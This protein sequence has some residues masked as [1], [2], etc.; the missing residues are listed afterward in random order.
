MVCEVRSPFNI[1]VQY[2][3]NEITIMK[4]LLTIL[5]II[6]CF[7]VSAQ[8]IVPPFENTWYGF[9]VSTENQI[10]F[11]SSSKM[12][13]VDNDGD[14][15]VVA[16]RY[17]AGFD[18]SAKGFFVIKNY[19]GGMFNSQAAHY[20]SPM[21]SQFAESADLNNDNLPDVIVA[22]TGTNYNGNTVS[23][24][25][26]QGGGNFGPFTSYAVGGGP[27]GIVSDDFNNDG[28]NDLAVANY[29]GFD[30]GNTI[31]VLLNNG[32]GTF[33]P[34]SVFPAG[35]APY[36]LEAAKINGDNF[37]DIVVANENY[38]LNVLINSGTGTFT[39]RTELTYSGSGNDVWP[40]VWL[41][42]IDNDT[43][44]DIMYACVASGP[45]VAL[46]RNN[47]GNFGPF[48]T[49]NLDILGSV[50]TDIETSD[51]NGDGWQDIVGT[52]TSARSSDGYMVALSNGSGGFQTA[53]KNSAGQNTVDVML[54]DA[55]NDG[56]TDILTADSFSRMI[57]I[58]K[59]T[60]GGVFYS[61]VLYQTSSSFAASI[62]AADIDGDNDLDVVTSAS[63]RTAT[64]VPV[65][66][67]KNNGDGSF[68]SAISYSIRSGG[69]QA[70]FRDLNGD[71]KPDLLFATAINSPPYD[72][73]FAI[74]NGD[75]TFGAVQTK[76]VN[77]CGWY[78]IDG[79]DIDNDGDVDVLITEWLGCVGIPESGQRLFISMNDGNANFS[80]PAVKII[81]PQPAPIAI[82]DFN[83]DGNKDLAIGTSGA[84]MNILFGTGAGSFNDP[85]PNSIGDQGGATDIT[86]ADFNS[87]G[88]L[89]IASSNFFETTW[90]SVLYGNSDGTFQPAQS[91][92]SAYSPDL[93]NVSGITSGDLDNDGDKDIMV[94]NNASNCISLYYNN[95]G[96]F[97][98]ALRAGAYC[99]V[100]SPLFG[101][102]NNDNK[103]DLISAVS[104]PPSGIASA[105]VLLK[106]RNTGPSGI[107]NQL[108]GNTVEG[109]KLLQ[110]YPNPFNP[111]TK[112]RFE[113]PPDAK[114]AVSEVSLVVYDMLGRTV[115]TLVSQRFSAGIYEY[116]FSGA[117]LPSGVYFYKLNAGKFSAVKRM[118][119]I[120]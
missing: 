109:Y 51:L 25:L 9:N 60:G 86:V 84:I 70:K 54:G 79:A 21:T 75:G 45:S 13:D 36:R 38:H 26:N 81:G 82:A 3:S 53:F 44:K 16:S 116:E 118:T 49:I 46:Y 101:D 4:I 17:F 37:I 85:I 73:H 74:N 88:K 61:P 10:S 5:F 102:F 40:S 115:S 91:L 65:K 41:A 89:D 105:V 76:P 98:Y 14:S 43:D 56:K 52:S 62:D 7:D 50:V 68:A 48:E 6:F 1:F 34:Q 93:L 66:V 69:V 114:S 80:N 55:D 96:S 23:V 19:G 119:L 30:Q 59:N 110:N 58:H 113:I 64:G 90:M 120:K 31:S 39:N 111:T 71:N 2:K 87:D 63:G 72:F 83:R 20:S 11:L 29:G 35:V 117:N 112:I 100:M 24:Y 28:F 77:A 8:T 32:N 94:G 103:G 104:L 67:L 97:T 99:S 78:D 92:P 22:N 42:D 95:G 27:I 47:N 33:A 57:T 18:G 12:V 108:S 15:D 106:G 107:L